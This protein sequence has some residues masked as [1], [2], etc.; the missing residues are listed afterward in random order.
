MD[1]TNYSGKY[2][3]TSYGDIKSSK[4]WFGKI[5]LLGLISFIPIFGQMTKRKEGT[6]QVLPGVPSF[7]HGFYIDSNCAWAYSSQSWSKVQ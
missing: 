3:R 6:P 2:F 4:G 7:L 5:C 1:Q